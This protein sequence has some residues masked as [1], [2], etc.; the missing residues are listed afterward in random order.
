MALRPAEGCNGLP[1]AVN[2]QPIVALSTIGEAES[3]VRQCVQGDIPTGRS[4][5]EGPLS[6]SNRL[7]ILTRMVEIV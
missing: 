1:V 2:R 5:R 6:S 4:K 7:V 3:M